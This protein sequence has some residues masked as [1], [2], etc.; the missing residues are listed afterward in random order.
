MSQAG[1]LFDKK[2]GGGGRGSGDAPGKQE[3]ACVP[4]VHVGKRTLMTA[5]L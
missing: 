1:K 5:Y 3:G 2:N 4:H